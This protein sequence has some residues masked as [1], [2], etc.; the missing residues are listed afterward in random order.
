[1]PLANRIGGPAIHQYQPTVLVGASGSFDTLVDMWCMHEQGHLPDPSQTSFVL[2]IGEFYRSY[3]LL[4]TKNHNE[5]MQL[6]GMIELRADMIVV[7]ICLID[8]VLKTYDI[9]E[10]RTSTYSLKEGVV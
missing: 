3:E 5:R 9:P 4:I 10:I 8:Y 1:M 2:P 7:A 6:P